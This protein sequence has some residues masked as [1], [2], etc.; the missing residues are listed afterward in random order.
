MTEI[1]LAGPLNININ[2]ENIQH[3]D[4]AGTSLRRRAALLQ[5]CVSTGKL[6]G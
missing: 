5:C 3:F 4:V 2:T 6:K 1:L